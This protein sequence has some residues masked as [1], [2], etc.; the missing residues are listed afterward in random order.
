LCELLRKTIKDSSTF[1]NQGSF[2]FFFEREKKI[3]A[4]KKF[5]IRT[6]K[7]KSMKN[8]LTKPVMLLSL[9]GSSY[10]ATAT[11]KQN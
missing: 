4:K 8:I 6:P 1:D 7:E 3:E 10:K 9:I 11:I 5:N 2:T